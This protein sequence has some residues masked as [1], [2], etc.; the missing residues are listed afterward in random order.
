[1]IAR[2]PYNFVDTYENTILRDGEQIQ[3]L[4]LMQSLDR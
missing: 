4:Y 2:L 3:I 1:M